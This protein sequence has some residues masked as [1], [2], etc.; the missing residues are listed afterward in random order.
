MTERRRP[1]PAPG[2]LE[3]YAA[4]FDDLW[5]SVAQRRGL[6]EYLAGLL[7]PRDRNKTLTALAGAEPLVGAQ[8][9]PVQ[10]LQYFLSESAWDPQAVNDR[11]LELVAADAATV[12]H[13]GGVLVIDDSGDRKD[14]P[15]TAHVARQYLG[16]VGKTDNGIVT[17]TTLWADERVYYPLHVAPYTP[18]ARLPSGSA[19]AQFATKPRLAVE[20]VGRAVAA[21]VTFRAVVADS[22]YGPSETG[23]LV[24]AL[25]KAGLAYVVALKPHRGFWAR[26]QDAHTPIEAAEQL[27]WH[28]RRRRGDWRKVLRRFRDGHT[29]TWWAA[30]ATLDGWGPDRDVRLVVATT[31]PAALPQRSTWYLVTNLP[32]PDG[33]RSRRSKLTPAD[34]EEIVRLYGLRAWVEQGYKQLKQELGWADFQVRSATAILRHYILVCVAF[35]F[36]WQAWF[37]GKPA[38]TPAPAP[39][40]S[41]TP[42]TDQPVRRERGGAKHHPHTT[43]QHPTATMADGATSG[44]RLADPAHTATTLLA[45][46]VEHAPT[47]RA[48]GP[49]HSRR[50]WTTTPPLHPDL[51]NYRYRT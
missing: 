25:G 18:A 51:T 12:W 22:V 11:R 40:R 26:A 49:H 3:D 42:A 14:G 4:R 47:T 50:Q 16:S 8:Q 10:R 15:A 5:R 2:P 19:D 9:A 48:A 7:L 36:C 13:P 32:R 6:R 23:E 20:L 39:P 37:T 24:A 44:P 17:V 31:D 30:D 46:L 38:H 34:L 28:S 35:S 33:P 27:G 1:V 43:R 29:E 41:A 45:V 21:G